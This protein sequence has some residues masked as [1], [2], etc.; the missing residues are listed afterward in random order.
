MTGIQEGI[1][2]EHPEW[3]LPRLC[4]QNA[5]KTGVYVAIVTALVTLPLARRFGLDSNRALFTA[6]AA[7]SV[8]GYVSAKYSFAHCEKT[9]DFF[10]SMEQIKHDKQ[11]EHN[12][13]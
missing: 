13:T 8:G 10:Q 5:N 3:I 4:Q 1:A 9:Y 12:E 6:M 7:S 11:Q 2:R